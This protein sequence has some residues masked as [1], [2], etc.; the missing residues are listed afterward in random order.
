MGKT[1]MVKHAQT[2]VILGWVT[3]EKF[4]LI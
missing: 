4:L 3:P 2:G 1:F